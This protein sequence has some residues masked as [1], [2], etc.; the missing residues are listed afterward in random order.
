MSIIILNKI[1]VILFV[2]AWVNIL[3]H[4]FF[5]FLAWKRNADEKQD[6]YV[7]SQRGLFLLGLSIAYV[8]TSIITGIN[9]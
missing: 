3:R 4:G 7:I 1:L 6:E 5:T 9:L 8:V 2:F